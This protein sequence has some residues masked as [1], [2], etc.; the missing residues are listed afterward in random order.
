[1]LLENGYT[2]VTVSQVAEYMRGEITLP[3]KSVALTFDDGW[4]DNFSVSENL[5][6]R[7]MTGTF[8][9]ITNTF[10][11]PQY[12]TSAQVGEI[13]RTNEIGSHSESHFMQ[14]VSNFSKIP[15][16][17]MIKEFATSK[18]TLEFI[19][20]KP[21]ISLSWPFGYNRPELNTTLEEMGYKSAVLVNAD[22]QNVPGNSAMQ[23]HRIIVD[24][25]CNDV[26]LLRMI[27]SGKEGPCN[28]NNGLD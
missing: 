5:R 8:Y 19:V 21:I 18:A 16:T 27:K 23:I 15:S 22:S 6:V 9:I 14:Y 17:Q 12:L 3:E 25:G 1:M 26:H 28:E 11:D 10:G 24:G 7:G 13:S 2:T 20:G 4:A